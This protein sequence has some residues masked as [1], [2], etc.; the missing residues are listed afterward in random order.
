MYMQLQSAPYFVLA[1]PF[2]QS[3]T[4]AAAVM[5]LQTRRL[6]IQQCTAAAPSSAHMRSFPPNS[7]TGGEIRAT[8]RKRLST[9]CQHACSTRNVFLPCVLHL[10]H[11]SCIKTVDPC[12]HRYGGWLCQCQ[13]HEELRSSSQEPTSSLSVSSWWCWWCTCVPRIQALMAR[14]LTPLLAQQQRATSPDT[15]DGEGR[16][17]GAACVAARHDSCWQTAAPRGGRQARHRGQKMTQHRYNCH[18]T[19][20][21]AHHTHLPAGYSTT[22]VHLS[23]SALNSLLSLSLWILSLNTDTMSR[24]ATG[25]ACPSSMSTSSSSQAETL[26]KNALQGSSNAQ[27]QQHHRW[28]RTK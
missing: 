8:R 19:P 7:I 10:L 23:H 6:S 9:V 1:L 4:A 22:P 16:I 17:S 18:S 25:P 28:L 27:T 15:R 21:H 2:K 13:C 14:H 3:I 24:M 20:Q 11:K 26:T 12:Q 5:T